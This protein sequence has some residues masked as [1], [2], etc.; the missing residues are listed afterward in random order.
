VII[1]LCHL[2]ATLLLLLLLLNLVVRAGY[3]VSDCT[4]TAED[5][6]AYTVIEV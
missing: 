5:T 2:R 4:T 3:W 6:V 1:Q